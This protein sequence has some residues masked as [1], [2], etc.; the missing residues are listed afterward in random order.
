MSQPLS[1]SGE[2]ATRHKR[3]GRGAVQKWSLSTTDRC[4]KVKAIN[5]AGAVDVV[6]AASA[7]MFGVVPLAAV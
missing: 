2:R 3:A 7:D 1:P 6:E 5:D 4:V